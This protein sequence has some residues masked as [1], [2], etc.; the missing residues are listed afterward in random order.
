[1]RQRNIFI[2]A[3]GNQCLFCLPE[4]AAGSRLSNVISAWQASVPLLQINNFTIYFLHIDSK[5]KITCREYFRT[6]STVDCSEVR[7]NLV[8]EDNKYISLRWNSFRSLAPF[9][10]SLGKMDEFLAI[11]SELFSTSIRSSWA[12]RLV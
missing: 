11:S 6:L 1:M 7:F 9:A 3:Y 8:E 2:N 12:W 10:K 4:K 5:T